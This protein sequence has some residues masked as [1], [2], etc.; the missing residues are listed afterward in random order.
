MKILSYR[1]QGKDTYGVLAG[2]GVCDVGRR[3][4]DRYPDLGA[5]LAAG[6]LNEI[7]TA[8]DG[9]DEAL[10]RRVWHMLLGA[11]YERRQVPP[12]VKITDRSFGRD[13]RYPITD[14][15]SDF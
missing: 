9:H 11:E 7:A 6:A 10:V 4:G 5:V 14:A 15:F 2:D 12:G 13:R 3:I 8:A 1:H